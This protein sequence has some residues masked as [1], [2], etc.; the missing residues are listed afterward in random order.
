MAGTIFRIQSHK[1]SQ[2]NIQATLVC[3][4]RNSYSTLKVKQSSLSARSVEPR[5]KQTFRI[6]ALRKERSS[7]MTLKRRK[8][9]DQMKSLKKNTKS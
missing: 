7:R 3:S 4:Q 9:R 2:D 8:K 1:F 5:V 6:R